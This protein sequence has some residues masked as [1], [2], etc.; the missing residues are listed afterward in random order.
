MS[1]AMPISFRFPLDAESGLSLV[2]EALLLG[3]PLLEERHVAGLTVFSSPEVPMGPEV[4]YVCALGVFD[5]VHLGHRD[6]IARAGE[7]ARARGVRL[8]V[9]TFDPDP[10]EVLG[11]PARGERLLSLGLRV[12]ALSRAGADAVVVVPFTERLSRMS[13]QEFVD[14]TLMS[15]VRPV[16]VHVGDNFRFGHLGAGT[17]ADLARIGEGLGFGVTTHGLLR[18]AGE[19]VSATRVRS[20]LARGRV[21]EAAGLLGRYH[22]VTGTIEHGRG[23]GTGFGFPT[24][25]VRCDVR[26]AVPSEG[27]YACYV[28]I[29]GEVWP[30]AVNVGA[31]PT[32][33]GPDPAFMEANLIG[34]SG[35]V[36]G[37][38][39]SVVF[40]EWLRAS[41][42]FSST[43]E[44]ERVV[45]GNIDWVR[46]NLGETGLGRLI[47]R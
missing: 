28:V 26:D 46:E 23:Q 15:A 14:T 8:A 43:A 13:P 4:D 44:L 22:A 36:Y 7:D 47:D 37:M 1:D 3:T 38:S 18:S 42:R 31:P 17:P 5:G 12:A 34:F 33:S 39:A 29:D 2:A 45:M 10:S 19:P 21:G 40:V 11:R 30:A 16:S 24:A 20:L 9:V 41:R 32:F 35:D 6:L 27:V 25:N